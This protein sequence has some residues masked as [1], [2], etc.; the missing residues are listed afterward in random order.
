ME[1]IVIISVIL[2]AITMLYGM[3]KLKNWMNETEPHTR[4]EPFSAIDVGNS[5]IINGTFKQVF[6]KEDSPN[7]IKV[8]GRMINVHSA[9][10]EDIYNFLQDNGYSPQVDDTD[11]KIHFSYNGRKMC[12]WC[13]SVD[14]NSYDIALMRSI[15]E[16][17]ISQNLLWESIHRVYNNLSDSKMFDIRCY[18]KFGYLVIQKRFISNTIESYKK[19]FHNNSDVIL[20]VYTK[21]KEAY[22]ESVDE[23]R[24]KKQLQE[25][26][27]NPLNG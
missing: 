9:L 5:Q 4:E 8:H 1:A 27:D 10:E 7:V 12:T 15:A 19:S 11:G 21:V 22:N 2:L 25:K 3:K 23:I 6:I 17:K 13:R 16:K 20:D 24:V 26:H 14:D 18:I